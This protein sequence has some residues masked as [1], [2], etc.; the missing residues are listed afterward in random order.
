MQTKVNFIPGKNVGTKDI[1]S[2]TVTVHMEV[3][4][5]FD[6]N[7]HINRP[8]KLTASGGKLVEPVEFDCSLSTEGNSY[9]YNGTHK[10][11]A[12]K[13]DVILPSLLLLGLIMTSDLS[14]SN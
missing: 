13:L 2:L 3:P 10:S 14:L 1:A 7:A 12:I 5:G 6:P 4:D 8:L 11:Y 9:F